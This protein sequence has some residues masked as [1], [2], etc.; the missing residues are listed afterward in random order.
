MSKFEDLMKA[1]A[2]IDESMGA[3]VTR[4]PGSPPPATSSAPARWQGVGKSKNALEI[5]V[6][7]V[8]PDPD[9]PREEFD[10]DALSRLAESLRT[11]GQLQT[12]RVRWEESRGAYV[13]ICG[14]RRWRAA[15][16]AGL[17]TIGAIV[18]EGT[19]TPAELLAV[20]LVENC[21][22]EDLRPVEQSKAYRALME[23]N[24]WSIRQL[25]GEL[26]LD[27]SAVARALKLLDLPESVQSRV[28]RGDISTWTAY[29]I[30]KVG[31]AAEQEQLAARA[32]EEKLTRAGVV[33]AREH[34]AARPKPRKLEVKA[35]NGC[36]V[37]V[38]LP[39]PDL[40]DDDALVALQHALK[41]LKKQRASRSEAAS[42][43]SA[44]R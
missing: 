35:P 3:G 6:G 16:K 30:A 40:D 5:P 28:E 43:A 39:D 27:H 10:E 12:I 18:V 9:Q 33:A 22:R 32:V 38:I 41:V 42:F 15:V 24:G 25:A 11:R 13:I 2:N 37:A 31:D 26:A 14:E 20:Q 23:Q 34:K 8:L 36:T 29:E 19:M 21:L 4:G 44:D 1:G 17:P 7:K